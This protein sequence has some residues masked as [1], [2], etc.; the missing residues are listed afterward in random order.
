MVAIRQIIAVGCLLASAG[1]GPRYAYA[2]KWTAERNLELP[3]GADRSAL[4]SLNRVTLEILTEGKFTLWD[5]SLPIEGE[6]DLAEKSQ[7]LDIRY[8]AGRPTD[9]R[10]A[11]ANLSYSLTWID[12]NS[13][14]LR[15][16]KN[17]PVLLHRQTKP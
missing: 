4:T 17:P 6:M 12:S 1:C 16:D 14:E 5:M 15:N 10:N 2:G 13:L 9:R 11:G 8:V 7:K 3:H